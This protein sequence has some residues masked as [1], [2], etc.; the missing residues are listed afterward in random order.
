MAVDTGHSRPRSTHAGLLDH[1]AFHRV[2]MPR[3]ELL[4]SLLDSGR[5]L[6]KP[7]Q[8]TARK[9][10]VS[11]MNLPSGMRAWHKVKIAALFC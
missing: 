11:V 2:H 1:A 7:D 5:G 10:E 3:H 4:R 9:L 6:S 8:N